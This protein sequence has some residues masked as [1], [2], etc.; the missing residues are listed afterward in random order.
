[1]FS[2]FS[3][4]FALI[5]VKTSLF[6]VRALVISHLNTSYLLSHSDR[7]VSS[8]DLV[9]DIIVSNLTVDN[10]DSLSFILQE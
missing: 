2:A 6:S 4:H 8:S 10:L 9:R 3:Y 1:M 5:E 7:P